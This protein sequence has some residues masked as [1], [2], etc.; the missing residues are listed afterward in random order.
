M[1][2]YAVKLECH[3]INY[4]EVEAENK[5]QAIIMAIDERRGMCSGDGMHLYEIEIIKD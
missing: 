5:Q 3:T 1:K 4:T 2:K